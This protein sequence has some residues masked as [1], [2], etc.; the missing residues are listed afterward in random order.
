MVV[1]PS[2]E[3]PQSADAA[4]ED[5]AAAVEIAKIEADRDI[6][7]AEIHTESNEKQ[8]D[9]V[10]EAQEDQEDAWLRNELDGLSSSHA[11][12]A[13]ELSAARD[14]ILAL[15]ARLTI[16]EARIQEMSETKPSTPSKPS[17]D[18]TEDKTEDKSETGDL[19]NADDTSPAKEPPEDKT[20][21]APA[22]R[23]IVRM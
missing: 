13:A 1:V 23:P 14:V 9:A 16:A 3:A 15:E 10:L 12:L 7:L 5:A 18:K 21:K 20:P 17:E 2:I 22:R 8:T 6:A 11:T 19:A 4:S